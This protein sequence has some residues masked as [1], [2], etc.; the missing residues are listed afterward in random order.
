MAASLT[1]AMNASC[2]YEVIGGDDSVANLAIPV[3]VD[4]TALAPLILVASAALPLPL[5]TAATIP[6]SESPPHRPSDG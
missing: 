4:A 5:L 2:R 1:R 6:F 3:P